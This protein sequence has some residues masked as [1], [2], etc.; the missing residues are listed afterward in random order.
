M[1]D[2]FIGNTTGIL[3]LH[4]SFQ[5]FQSQSQHHICHQADLDLFLGKR[6]M[7]YLMNRDN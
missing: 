5:Q 3:K 1:S 7:S 4:S 6:K 2:T